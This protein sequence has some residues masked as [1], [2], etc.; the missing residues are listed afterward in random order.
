MFLRINGKPYI[1]DAQADGIHL[2]PFERWMKQ[3]NY[4]FVATRF[5]DMFITSERY[6]D[7]SFEY[8]DFKYGYF[9]LVRHW[10]YRKVGLWLGINKEH[11]RL[12]CSELIMMVR[13]A[14]FD[15]E[16]VELERMSPKD[17]YIWEIDNGFVEV[18]ERIR[19]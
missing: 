11:K 13:E 12:V 18:Y 6:I 14:F 15:V 10:I 17:V 5:K 16:N 3:Y 7:A 2:R 19:R 1:L 9:D 8:L 4:N